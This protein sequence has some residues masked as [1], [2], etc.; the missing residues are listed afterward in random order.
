MFRY[1]LYG[2]SAR[3]SGVGAA[4]EFSGVRVGANVR[5]TVPEQTTRMRL[6]G[7][8][9]ESADAFDEWDNPITLHVNATKAKRRTVCMGRSGVV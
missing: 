4:T 8:S 2:D 3:I 1:L 5:K 9:A 7:G 6:R